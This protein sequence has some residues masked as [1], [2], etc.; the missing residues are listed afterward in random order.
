MKILVS[1]TLS[2]LYLSLSAQGPNEDFILYY[3]SQANTP[4]C[5]TADILDSI[6]QE[7][8]DFT[9]DEYFPT[10]VNHYRFTPSGDI[11]TIAQL[12]VDD[13]DTLGLPLYDYDSSGNQ[14]QFRFLSAKPD[15]ELFLAT[16]INYTYDQM[17]RLIEST[18]VGTNFIAP[19]DTLFYSMDT[20]HDHDASGEPLRIDSQAFDFLTRRWEKSFRTINETNASGQITNQATIWW[21]PSLMVYSDT[22]RRVENIFSNGLIA[23]SSTYTI[24]VNIPALT[25]SSKS[26][27]EYDSN[28][29]RISVISERVDVDGNL[30]LSTKTESSFTSCDLP[31]IETTFRYD[32]LSTEWIPVVRNTHYYSPTVAVNEISEIPI[33]T[34]PNPTTGHF[35]LSG[36]EEE[37]ALLEIYDL[38]GDKL[39]VRKIMTTESIDLSQYPSGQYLIRLTSDNN[40]YTSRIIKVD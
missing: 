12:D 20:Y 23:C 22:V 37:S 31:D 18:F 26:T 5:A 39:D 28:N 38:S 4:S 36:I 14:A 32:T 2:L 9:F 19:D 10:S 17:D 21:N 29:N 25:L 16:E 35:I 15:G 8:Y 40:N 13:R 3:S 33:N 34:Y 27:T 30:Y 24:P 7:S 1:V 6:R 11:H